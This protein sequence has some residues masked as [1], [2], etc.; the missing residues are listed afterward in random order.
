MSGYDDA[1]ASWYAELR[2][3]RPITWSA[4]L[5][6]GGR[7]PGTPVRVGAAH[8]EVVRRLAERLGD[9]AGFP[10]LADRVVSTA[11][12]GRGRVDIP[13]PL[14]GGPV[15]GPPPMDPEQ[16]PAGELLRVAVPVLAEM[17]EFG[18][19]GPVTPVAPTRRPRRWGAP[20]VVVHG[21]PGIAVPLRAA[22]RRVERARDP[23]GAAGPPP[24]ARRGR[25]TSATRPRAPPV[26]GVRHAAPAEHDCRG[27]RSAP[28]S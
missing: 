22:L 9:S 12:F 4:H 14:P 13:L 8:L 16:I 26:G 11:A 19:V 6:G 27:G 18:P 1:V 17:L 23:F 24:P 28:F 2:A 25:R 21:N 7:A 10:E 20:R 3:G 15:P 5:A